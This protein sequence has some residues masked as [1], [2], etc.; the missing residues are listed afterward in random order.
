LAGL[1]GETAGG[2]ARAKHMDAFVHPRFYA[3]IES[4]EFEGFFGGGRRL[5]TTGLRATACE[6]EGGAVVLRLLPTA[7][8]VFELR[9][10]T[11]A[12]LLRAF[13][14]VEIDG[15]GRAV[16]SATAAFE[17][18]QVWGTVE[19]VAA[20]QDKLR[21]DAVVELAVL[22][23]GNVEARVVAVEFRGSDGPV[24]RALHRGDHL[25]LVCAEAQGD[26]GFVYGAQTLAFVLA[27]RRTAQAGRVTQVDMRQHTARATV[28]QLRADMVGVTVLA[29]VAAVSANMPAEGEARRRALRVSDATATCDAT[30]WGALAERAARLRVGQ[31]VLLQSFDTHTEH[32]AVMLN[33]STDIHSDI[34][35]V[36]SLPALPPSA[37]LR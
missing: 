37:R 5:Y 29:R 35:V 12:G 20:S 3:M 18:G 33:G 28:S 32:G 34:V 36:S 9:A 15:G 22:E 19:S 31:M 17:A 1:E 8:A 21:G 7:S 14:G 24:A 23:P 13:F 16:Q 10:T 27:G 30:V 2:R 25:G 11:D 4:A 26:A 6:E